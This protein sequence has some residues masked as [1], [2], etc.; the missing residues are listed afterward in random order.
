VRM[1]AT[2]PAGCATGEEI[3]LVIRPEDLEVLSK[4]EDGDNI[5]PARLAWSSFQGSQCECGVDIG[6]VELRATIHSADEEARQGESVWLRF[7][8]SRCIAYR[9][10]NCGKEN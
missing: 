6:G 9:K 7:E 5:V 3:D 1:R 2:L 10:Q 4:A 8:P